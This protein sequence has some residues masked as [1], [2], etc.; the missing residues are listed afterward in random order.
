MNMTH[1]KGRNVRQAQLLGPRY[2]TIAAV[3]EATGVTK[4]A[5]AK[6]LDS[7]RVRALKVGRR[8]YVDRASLARYLGEEAGGLFGITLGIS[9]ATASPLASR[10]GNARGQPPEPVL[11]AT[12]TPPKPPF[13]EG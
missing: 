9:G 11:N 2:M 5:V 4:A 1:I 3:V 12:P 7:G 13:G 10:E 8:R 6:W